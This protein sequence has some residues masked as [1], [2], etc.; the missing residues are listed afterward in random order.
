MHRLFGP[1][2]GHNAVV[3]DSRWLPIVYRVFWDLPRAFFCRL[4]DAWLYV[5]A[6]F[7]EELD[8]FGDYVVFDMGGDLGPN[9]FGGNWI[10][11]PSHARRVLGTVTLTADAFDRTRR[12]K[13][14]RPALESIKP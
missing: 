7:D 12:K 14:L 5:A 6:D 4:E 1:L 13:V 10:E 11:V 8:A 2:D 3:T 9:A